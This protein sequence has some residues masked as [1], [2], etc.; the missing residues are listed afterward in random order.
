[1]SLSKYQD[2][3]TRWHDRKLRLDGEP[4]SNNGWIYTAYA[5]Y[6][7][8]R[9]V[10]PELLEICYK[11]C[12]RDLAPIKV[13]RSP[14]KSQPPLSKDEVIGLV[15]LKLLKPESLKAS[16][17][18]FCSLPEY[19]QS[20]YLLTI[21][22]LLKAVKALWKIRKEHRNYVWQNQVTAAYPLAFRLMP[23]DTY[24]VNKYFNRKVKWYETLAFGINYLFVL[25][26]NDDSIRNLTWLQLRDLGHNFLAR[27]LKPKKSFRKYFGIGHPFYHSRLLK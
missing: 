3:W 13:D 23:W 16:H 7:V 6:L 11:K 17:W 15:H 24:Y 4:S 1:M 20:K 10:N 18:N 8:P 26:G 21:K 25:L 27:L 5:S 9:S 14:Y 2:K 19:D 12:V 22:T